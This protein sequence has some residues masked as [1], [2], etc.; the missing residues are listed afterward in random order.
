MRKVSTAVHFERSNSETPKLWNKLKPTSTKPNP[1][2]P[3][4]NT[5]PHGH[6][7][8]ISR[9]KW[10]Y[11]E[12]RNAILIFMLQKEYL[13]CCRSTFYVAEG[14]NFLEVDNSDRFVLEGSL[15]DMM[16]HTCERHTHKGFICLS[17]RRVLPL[18]RKKVTFYDVEQMFNDSCKLSK[19]L[20][21]SVEKQSQQHKYLTTSNT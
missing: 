10:F 5:T 1:L 16:N 9:D 19:N 6:Q 11:I 8:F 21:H 18:K 2:A 3:T 15:R 12:V 7:T 4:S 17:C 14:A 13:L 20:H